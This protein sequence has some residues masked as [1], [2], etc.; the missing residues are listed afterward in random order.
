MTLEKNFI[1]PPDLPKWTQAFSQVVT[2]SN[3]GLLTIYLSGQVSVDQDNN[4]VGGDDLSK[5]ADQAFKNLELALASVGATTSDVV[6]L[7]IYVKNYRFEDA[8]KIGDALRKAFPHENLPAST[9][10]GVQSLAVE[11]LLIEID[12]IAVVAEKELVKL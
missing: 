7:N 3:A 12:A 2:V 5:Q 10:L 8:G 4:L 9:W 11:G 6:K 1:N